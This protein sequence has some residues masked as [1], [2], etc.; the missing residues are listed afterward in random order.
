MATDEAVDPARP[1]QG[2]DGED[3]PIPVQVS[4]A[5]ANDFADIRVLESSIN[6]KFA[7]LQ[8][9]VQQHDR[10]MK[11]MLKAHQNSVEQSVKA[12]PQ[13]AQT[14]LRQYL[15]DVLQKQDVKFRPMTTGIHTELAATEKE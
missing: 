15:D 9:L 8:N 13:K 10:S 7:E 2:D 5:Q 11:Q 4:Y 12:Q 1:K 6:A 14:D 3:A